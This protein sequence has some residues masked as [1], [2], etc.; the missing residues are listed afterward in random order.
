MKK[1][2][3]IPPPKVDRKNPPVVI[4]TNGLGIKIC[5]GCP[6]KIRKEQQVHPNNMVFRRQGP[7]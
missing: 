1:N 4:F 7:G 3:Q 5:K 2:V 6:R